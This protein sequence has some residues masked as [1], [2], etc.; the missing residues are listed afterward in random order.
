VNARRCEWGGVVTADGAE[1]EVAIAPVRRRAGFVTRLERAA[2]RAREALRDALPRGLELGGYSTHVSLSMPATLNEAASRLFLTTFAPGLMLLADRADS[3]GLLVRPRPGRMELAVEYVSG[4]HLRAVTAYAAGAAIASAAAL[5]DGASLPPK[6][7]ARAVVT[8][9]R[10]GW[11][12]A[13][14]AFGGDLLRD[15]RAALLRRTGGGTIRAQEHLELSWAA[16]RRALSSGVRPSDLAMADRVVSRRAPLPSEGIG[17]VEGFGAGVMQWPASAY[18]ALLCP[19][20]RPGFSV[21]AEIATWDVAVFAIAGH[22]RRAFAS[23]PRASLPRFLHA[24]DSGQLDRVIRAFVDGPAAGR[25]LS[26]LADALRPGLFDAIAPARA[27]VASE[28]TAWGTIR[29]DDA[30]YGKETP[31]VTPE[32]KWTIPGLPWFPGIP[33]IPGIPDV[34]QIPGIPWIPGIPTLPIAIL[35]GLVL[36][37][38]VVNA[39]TGGTSTV[40]SASG[41]PGIPAKTAAGTAPG[42]VAT[43]GPRLTGFHSVLE[44]PRTTYTVDVTAGGA[45]SY[46]WTATTSCPGFQPS[47]GPRAVWDHPHPPCPSETVHAGRITVTVRDGSGRTA[48]Y[49]YGG[50]SAPADIRLDGNTGGVVP[51]AAAGTLPPIPGPSAPTAASQGYRCDGAQIELFNNW[52]IAGVDDGGTAPSFSTGGRTYCLVWVATYHWNS[53]KG[54]PAGRIDLVGGAGTVS[55]QADPGTRTDWIYN[56]PV[57]AKPLL[58]GSYQCRDSDP[59]TWSANDQSAHQGFCKVIV[60]N[61]VK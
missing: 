24:L 61:A 54:A 26:G 13:R 47:T 39:I 56:A 20:E 49:T 18:G 42:A 48:T 57:D 5:R 4:P 58:S 33:R 25:Y 29:A 32:D 23:V 59:A 31:G 7:D 12:L 41:T 2:I 30:R 21:S 14:D 22:W 46:E 37:G 8:G 19:R 38:T 35:T 60:Q 15:G 34:V 50:G 44:P 9:D 51:S 10:F 27:F 28:T 17:A 11:G 3:P 45:I 16:A 53:G 55:G 52:N 43:G 40:P 36:F 6:L 1:A